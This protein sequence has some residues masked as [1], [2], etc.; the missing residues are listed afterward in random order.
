MDVNEV[1]PGLDCGALLAGD[2]SWLKF[3]SGAASSRLKEA[4]NWVRSSLMPIA[5]P[6]MAAR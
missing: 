4:S 5:S 2:A 3:L 1:T 6:S